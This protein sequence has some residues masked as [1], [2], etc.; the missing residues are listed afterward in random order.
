M[1]FELN[2]LLCVLFN[3]VLKLIKASSRVD[4]FMFRYCLPLK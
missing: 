4:F 2:R 1:P 3:N